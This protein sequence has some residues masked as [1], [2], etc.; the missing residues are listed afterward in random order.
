MRQ[1]RHGS[2]ALVNLV[3][4]VVAEEMDDVP[5]SRLTPAR[6]PSKLGA[7]VDEAQFGHEPD[8]T[9]ILKLGSEL[10]LEAVSGSVR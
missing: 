3:E 5:V 1:I 8:E 2:P 7:L 6:I 9:S 4:D 10:M